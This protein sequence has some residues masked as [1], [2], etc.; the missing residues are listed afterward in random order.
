MSKS[1]TVLHSYD[2][3]R[4]AL[5]NGDEANHLPSLLLQTRCW[6]GYLPQAEEYGQYMAGIAMTSG[7]G[8]IHFEISNSL[9]VYLTLFMTARNLL[10]RYNLQIVGHKHLPLEWRLP[11]LFDLLRISTATCTPTMEIRNS[12]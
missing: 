4:G 7:P 10:G 2:S 9:V 5:G 1:D 12:P 3:C 6:L 11:Y 8:K